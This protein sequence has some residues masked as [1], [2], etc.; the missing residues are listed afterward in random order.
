MKQF[1]LYLLVVPFLWLSSCV[2]LKTVNTFSKAAV[3]SLQQHKTLPITFTTLYQQRVQDDSLD[4]HPFKKIPLIG[5][6]FTERVRYDSLRSY[7]VADSLLRN[8]NQLLIDYFQAIAAFSDPSGSFVPVRLKSA[9]FD[10]FLQN[11]AIKLT[12]AETASFN[13]IANL[14]GSSATGAYRRR[15]LVDLLEN[16]HTDVQK[17]LAVLAFSYERLAEVT[18]ISREQQYGHY[19]TILIQDPTLTYLQKRTLAQQWLLTAG[20]IAKKRQAIHV[21]VKTLRTVS[22]GFDDLY[23]QRQQWK[24]K[25]FFASVSAYLTTLQQLQS[26]LEQLTPVYG[27]LHP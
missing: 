16:S 26:D 20:D 9:S 21:H 11:S 14:L 5:I 23:Q 13:R 10:S 4:R 27:R 18:D 1:Y 24:T 6:D 25:A 2:S 12:S 8:G 3:V 17:M 15:K 22:A 19:K 7:Q